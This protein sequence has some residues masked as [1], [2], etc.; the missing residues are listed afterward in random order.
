MRGSRGALKRLT[1]GVVSLSLLFTIGPTQLATADPVLGPPPA[2][3]SVSQRATI[4]VLSW[5]AVDGAAG[6]AVDYAL[7]PG[8]ATGS[9]TTTIEGYVVLTGLDPETLYYARVATWDQASGTNGE[10]GQTTS[11]TTAAKEFAIPAPVVAV[12][13]QT[14]TS[15]TPEWTSV[16]A[17][18]G[19]EVA[20]GKNPDEPDQSVIVHGDQATIEGLSVD[21][22]YYVSVRAIDASKEAV[23]AWSA[24]TAVK[25]PKVVSLRVASFNIKCANCKQKSELEWPKRK[26]AV[27]ATIRSQAPDVVGLQEASPSKL[28]GRSVSQ[29]QDL[30]NGLGSPYKV[31]LKGGAGVDNRIIYNSKKIKV[32]KT[33]VVALPKGGGR[34]FLVWAVLQQ[35]STGKKFLFGDTHLAPGKSKK[36]LRMNQTSTMV[37]ALK[38]LAKPKRLPTIVV[39]DFNMFKWMGGGYGPYGTMVAN[40]YLD[41][42][43]NTFHS[44]AAA[45]T[46][47]VEKRIRT[48]FSTF[49]DFKRKAPS[50][51]YANGTQLDFIFVTKMRVSE[52]ETVVKVDSNN[53]FVGTIPSDHNMVRADVWLP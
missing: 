47:F 35:R 24:A 16:G 8:F 22:T 53:Q 19:Y 1:L 3:V 45:P 13:S 39:G 49:N 37:S 30:L 26:A 48:N 12:S 23:T 38:K 28:H 44:Q 20:V 43:G 7:D 4:A 52:W 18:L 32:L 41:P 10:W 42:L 9:H 46:A 31:T 29:Y 33:G 17:K 27:V 6:Y 50:F 36:A 34:R 25:I 11:F 5:P 14:S 15:I 40:G 51:S 21:N 2:S